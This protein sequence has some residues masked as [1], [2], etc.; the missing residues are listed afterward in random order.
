MCNK[1]GSF[2]KMKSILTLSKWTK[3]MSKI[4]LSKILL[5]TK[6]FVS[7]MKIYGVVFYHKILFCYDIFFIFFEKIT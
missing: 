2:R 5:L 7:I 6:N 4:D 3:K 1:K